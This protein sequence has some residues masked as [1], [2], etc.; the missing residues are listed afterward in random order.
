M[1]LR[2]ARDLALRNS[3]TAQRIIGHDGFGRVAS[4]GLRHFTRNPGPPIT[5]LIPPGWPSPS[6]FD[7]GFPS[8]PDHP[9]AF[10]SQSEVASGKRFIPTG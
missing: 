8:G 2:Q 1:N 3:A 5:T 7:L 4:D 10:W 6:G 9:P